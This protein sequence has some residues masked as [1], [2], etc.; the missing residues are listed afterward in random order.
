MD[1]LNP[2]QTAAMLHKD[3]PALVIAGAGAGKTLTLVSRVRHLIDNHRIP[4]HNITAITFTSKAAHE[5]RNRLQDK[6]K[7]VFIGTFHRLGMW[8]IMRYGESIGIK[9]RTIVSLDQTEKA[10]EELMQRI[11]YEGKVR[12]RTALTLISKFRISGGLDQDTAIKY[13]DF[14]PILAFLI[15]AYEAVKTEKG[16]LDFD[17]LLIKSLHLLKV[18]KAAARKARERTLYTL[19]DEYQD[20]NPIHEELIST[21]QGG[22]EANLM[23]VGDPDQSIYAFNGADIRNILQFTKRRPSTA[24]Y[25]LPIN[26]RS[27]AKIVEIA[28]QAILKNTLRKKMQL[29]AHRPHG[30]KPQLLIC[31]TAKEEATL[32][33]EVAKQHGA[34]YPYEEMAVLSRST[35][36]ARLIEESM[37]RFGI[38][39]Q[40]GAGVR[41]Y[42]RA[43]IKTML[44]LLRV[45]ERIHTTDDLSRVLGA[46]VLNREQLEKLKDRG[47]LD[48]D[49]LTQIDPK[50]R[51]IPKAAQVK[52]FCTWLSELYLSKNWQ[53]SYEDIVSQLKGPLDHYLKELAKGDQDGINQRKDNLAELGIALG[54]YQEENP[55]DDLASFM[56]STL[57]SGNVEDKKGVLITTVHSAKGLEWKT[58]MVIGLYKNN[59]PSWG[60]DTAAALEEERR[61]FYVA[62]TR[63]K[64]NL[65]LSYPMTEPRYGN[66][67]ENSMFIEEVIDNL[68]VKE[69]ES[70]LGYNTSEVQELFEALG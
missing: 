68:E 35:A 18:N 62:L 56:A 49:K 69:Y 7:G 16:W 39:Y 32:V 31:E 34:L 37:L 42:D 11:R 47:Y 27:Q 33:G 70:T 23:A 43:E 24:V 4:P 5:M 10:I 19:V 52:S 50:S 40:L 60:A 64:E 13:A 36:A 25:T 30:D 65:L 38:P 3:G 8:L 26:Y 45:T 55:E 14:M 61:L 51:T 59:F 54:E 29:K 1:K 44:A 21:M 63:A 22:L 66:H 12:P 6:G 53:S 15:E 2:Y 17:D 41:F 9:G 20:T 57:V 58:V 28:N 48:L 67:V 46:F